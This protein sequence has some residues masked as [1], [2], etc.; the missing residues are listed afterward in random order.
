MSRRNEISD[1][2]PVVVGTVG[3]PEESSLSLP[4]FTII[5]H[6]ECKQSYPRLKRLK[7]S[8]TINI[9]L[10]TKRLHIADHQAQEHGGPR[11]T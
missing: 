2:T 1:V 11:R 9:D 5:F 7:K 6:Q 3:L 8:S 10:F 4:E